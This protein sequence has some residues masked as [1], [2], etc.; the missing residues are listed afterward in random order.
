VE[1]AFVDAQRCRDGVPTPEAIEAVAWIEADVDWTARRG[2]IPPAAIRAEIVFSFCWCCSLLNLDAED[3]RQHGLRRLS[4]FSHRSDVLL[5]GLPGI[6]EH[7][8]RA[9]HEYEARM[10]EEDQ[11]ESVA[12][13]QQAMSL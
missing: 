6:R 5:P 2:P 12:R 8:E 7:W 11:Q 13:E 10:S 9:R 4:G 1:S 3:I